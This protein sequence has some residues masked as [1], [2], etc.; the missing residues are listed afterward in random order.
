MIC[1]EDKGINYGLDLT[2]AIKYTKI[3]K[4]IKYTKI[5]KN[6]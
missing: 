6:N 1:V 3:M 5:H 2:D 4:T